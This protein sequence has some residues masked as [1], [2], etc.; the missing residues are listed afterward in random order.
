MAVRLDDL[1]AIEMGAVVLSQ[2]VSE[3]IVGN[4]H[5]AIHVGA[6]LLRHSRGDWGVISQQDR[7]SNNIAFQTGLRVVS[8]HMI[9]KGIHDQ[10]V[11]WVVTE[12]AR[13]RTSVLFPQEYQKSG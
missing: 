7:E 13:D 5:F 9:P 6:C 11:L 10:D 12:G 3:A 1:T 2:A 4:D 8:A